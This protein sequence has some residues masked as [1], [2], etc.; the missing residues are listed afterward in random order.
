MKSFLLAAFL[1]G[2]AVVAARADIPVPKPD[3]LIV[4]NLAAFS[5]TRFTIVVDRSSSQPL[6]DNKTYELHQEARLYVQDADHKPRL[7]LTVEHR[8]VKSETIQVHIKEVR[9]GSKGLEVS[10]DLEKKDLAPQPHT[11]SREILPQF[12]LAGLGC[13]GLVLIAPR[14]RRKQP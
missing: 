1:C 13:C 14:T 5:K 7:W 2:F 9:P 12:L 6:K 4:T 10:Y 3:Q 8:F 11:S